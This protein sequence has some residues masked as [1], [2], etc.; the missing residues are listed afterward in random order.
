M[1]RRVY[2]TETPHDQA[3]AQWLAAVAE[4]RG[5]EGLRLP[6]EEV[7]LD[8]C[9]GRITAG[10]VL[11]RRSSPH[12]PAAA[13]DGIAVRAEETTGAAE[14]T[15]VV[16]RRDQAVP[17]NTGEA[18]PAGC[19]AVVMIEY[20]RETPEGYEL[21]AAVAPWENVRPV[22]ED[23][24]VSEVILPE[25]HRIRPV[26]VGALLAGGVNRV[27][28]RRRPKVAIQ[29]TGTE[30]VDLAADPDRELRPGQI[31]EYNSRVIGG[32]VAEWG[33]EPLRRPPVPD[34]PEALREA[35]R[36]ALAEADV[37]AI[38]AGSS[39]GTRDYTVHVL[40]ELGRVVVHGV[41]LKPG[42][43]TILAV[44]DGK[45]VL[46]LPGYPVTAVLVAEL[47]LEP[48]LACLLGRA[49][50]APATVQA[51]LT[52]RM[53]SPPGVEEFLRVRVGE[54]DGELIA[55]P[56]AR[57]A[58]LITTLVRADGI[59]RIPRLSQGFPAGAPVAIELRR[60]LPEIRQTLF[61]AGSHDPL[62]DL[63]GSLLGRAY[64]GSGLAV[65]PLGSLGGLLALARREAHLAGTHLLDETTGEYNLPFLARYV[66]EP[67]AAINLVYRQ[68]GFLVPPGN[69]KAIRDWAD[70]IRPDISFLNRQRGSGTRLL[71]DLELK[72][73][74]IDPAA[75]RG[76]DRE[77]YTHTGLAAA[78]KAGTADV[79]V[80]LY[81]AARALGL[82]FLPVT[83]E[84]YDLVIPERLLGEERI[85][86]LL[87]VVRSAEFRE[88]AAAIGG[89]DTRQ[90][91]ERM[92]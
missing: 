58:G 11:A 51:K 50:A 48:L 22:G 26:D 44:V 5:P 76:Y 41:A 83:E 17:V 62:L 3:L 53:T 32:L 38:N 4:E 13:M 57:G 42:R 45:P 64:P 92:N 39:A 34:N 29:P 6:A 67:V 24:V 69:P 15:P 33:G 72:R 25:G 91:G 23:L 37:L 71:V 66:P 18:L 70:L 21:R 88:A 19:D 65:A 20:V 78:V 16:L 46:G 80:G 10:P 75:I 68:Q 73:R 28:V 54:V 31:V 52:R 30:L 81:A 55:S 27:A 84:R 35:I 89:Y 2:L 14:T 79:G 9:L 77:E 59:V 40:E 56:I 90:S 7:D 12:Y 63:L 8:S 82:D 86:R 43:P 47:F 60:S 36:Q 1:E 61:L 49:P 85:S 74:G 87:A